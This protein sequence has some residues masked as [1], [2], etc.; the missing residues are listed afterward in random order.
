[1][2]AHNTPREN[3]NDQIGAVLVFRSGISRQEAKRLITI[4]LAE[5]L[6]STTVQAFN[7]D[8]GSPVF[9]VP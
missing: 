4:G 1:M 9:Y 5:Y 3:P 8:H 6:H 2:P 7:P